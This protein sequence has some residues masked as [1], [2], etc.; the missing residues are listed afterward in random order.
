VVVPY[1]EHCL[2]G[3]ALPREPFGK[4]PWITITM[5]TMFHF[6][7]VGVIA[8]VQKFR[9]I[10]RRLFCRALKQK[11][12]TAVLTIDPTLVDYSKNQDNPIF[13]KVE[14]LPDPATDH[15]VLPSK[16]DTRWR[17]NIPASARVVLLYGEIGARKGVLT[18]LEAAADPAC[19][20]DVHIVLAGRCHD[21][22]LLRTNTCYQQ[23]LAQGRVHRMD[24]YLDDN[25]ERD[26]LAASDCMWVGYTEFY[27][28]SGIM[29]LAA[30]NG[31]PVLASAS[32]LIGYLTKLY[33][34]GLI[35]DPHDRLSVV[36][37]LTKLVRE[38]EF[39]SRAAENGIRMYDVHRPEELQRLVTEKALVSW[40]QQ[41]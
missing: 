7:D 16:V 10:R 35:L 6:D 18:L 21:Q 14:Y 19:P 23:L 12:L 5:R 24:G 20:S 37:A 36:A 29:V 22:T 17:L 27:L 32:G 28:M 30:R 34:T 25:Q 3:L 15:G 8:P 11:T 9:V 38:P 4:V 31:I 40:N 13:S 33:Q 2:V 39:F 41:P 1:L 26:I